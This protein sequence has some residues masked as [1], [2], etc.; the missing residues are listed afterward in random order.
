MNPIYQRSF[1]RL[2]DFNAEEIKYL[3]KLASTLKHQKN[4]HTE[5]QKLNKKNLVLIFENQSTRTRCAFEVAAF[6]QGA[7]ITCLTPNISQMGHKESIKDTA[8]ILGRMYHGIQYRG[9]HQNIVSI[10]SKY[11]GIPVWNGL[12]A[13]F[14]PTQLLADL[15][16]MQEHAP[17]KT[18]N[19]MILAYV[20]D[21]KNNIS[22]S[23][24]EAAAIMGFN[25]R[26]IA[27]KAF[28]PT[29][30]LFNKCKKLALKNNGN[31]ILT[32]DINDG[33]KNVDFL[34]TDVWVSMGENEKGW[35]KSIDLLAPYQVN[36]NMLQNTNNPNIKF[37]H[38]LPALHDQETTIGKKIAKKYNLYN[39]LEVTNDVFESTHSIVFDQ[40]ENRLHTIKALM[41][42]TLIP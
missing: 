29:Q 42:A 21:T 2:I 26:L 24:L 31:I 35:E 38:C 25:L 28:W 6:D 3:L 22:C 12:T 7:R 36:F 20:G 8:R 9:Y 37:L 41:I 27:P 40:A 16:T 32:E 19:Q 1:L 11:S 10:L 34:Y 33:V 4:T 39:G 13:Q 30:E 17:N 5:T 15:L 18:F 23:L 14:H